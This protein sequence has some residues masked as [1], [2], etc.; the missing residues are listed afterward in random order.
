VRKEVSP[1]RHKEHQEDR[2]RRQQ[3]KSWKIESSGIKLG[4]MSS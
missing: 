4:I 3:T 2:K 1:Q